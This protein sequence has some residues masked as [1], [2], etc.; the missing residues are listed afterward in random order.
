MRRVNP[1]MLPPTGRPKHLQY[2]KLLETTFHKK[3]RR[4]SSTHWFNADLKDLLRKRRFSKPDPVQYQAINKKFKRK[5]HETKEAW[6]ES[7][8]AE[9]ENL[10]LN[11]KEMFQ[12]ITKIVG[13][14]SSPAAKCIKAAD[15]TST[16]RC[17]G[18]FIP[19]GGIHPGPL[20]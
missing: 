11:A 13:K 20:P 7:K 3:G 2:G 9:V 8:C 6:L 10:S 12:K 4:K 18:S 15:G 16:S 17:K 1:R 19:V 5:C 14:T